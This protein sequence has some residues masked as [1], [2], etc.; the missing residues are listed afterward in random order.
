MGMKDLGVTEA[1]LA[2]QPKGSRDKCL[3]AWLVQER[4]L[5]KQEWV[6]SRLKMGASSAVGTYAKCIRDSNDPQ[7]I[8][9][10]TILKR[11]V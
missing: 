1:E 3:L 4:T 9:L 7:T 8:R 2:R 10:R 6:A 5:A 11:H